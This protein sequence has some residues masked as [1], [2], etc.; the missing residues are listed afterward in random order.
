MYIWNNGSVGYFQ[1]ILHLHNVVRRISALQT[2]LS[3]A[4]GTISTVIVC[5]NLSA[6]SS[7]FVYIGNSLWFL[8]VYS[9]L[10]IF[11]HLYDHIG[12]FNVVFN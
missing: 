6:F 3:F 7:L 2:A 4:S 12:V 1:T 11:D 8:Y 5:I 10:N 9:A